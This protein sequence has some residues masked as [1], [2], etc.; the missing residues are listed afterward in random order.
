MIRFLLSALLVAFAAPALACPGAESPCALDAGTYRIRLPE[1]E[2]RGV[3]LWL[4]GWGGTAAAAIAEAAVV[5]PMLARGYAVLAP[6]GVPRREGEPGGRWNSR[7]DPASRD[8]VAFLRAALADAGARFG[9][10]GLPALAAGFSGGGMMVWRLACDAPD[11]ADAYAPVAGLLWR[12][13]PERCAGPVSLLHTHGWRD[14]VVPIEGRAVAGGRLVQGDL[15]R[16]LAMLRRT[17]ACEADAPESYDA[18][19]DLLI[20]RWRCGDAALAL[21]LHP[22]GHATPDRWATLA[23]DWFEARARR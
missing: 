21:A 12:P 13:L 4:H 20:R 11:A 8:D 9:L 22:G 17:A 1:G 5:D 15:F 16:G 10:D 6:Q 19:G 18:E 23:L 3:A 2:P 7:T 14:T